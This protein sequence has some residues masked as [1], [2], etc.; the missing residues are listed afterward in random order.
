MGSNPGW[1]IWGYNSVGKAL[2]LQGKRQQFESA[3]SILLHESES[4]I[5]AR[6]KK[7]KFKEIMAYGG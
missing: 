6:N 5:E 4:K 3:I 2:S 1:P 7:N